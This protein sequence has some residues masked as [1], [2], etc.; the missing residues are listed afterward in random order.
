MKRIIGFVCTKML[1]LIYHSNKRQGMII[2][3]MMQG[4]G[5]SATVLFVTAISNGLWTYIGQ[6]TLEEAVRGR[7]GGQ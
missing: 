2:R 5:L 1:F 3:P 6:G 4:V 7:L